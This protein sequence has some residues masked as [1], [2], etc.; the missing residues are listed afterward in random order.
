MTEIAERLQFAV[1]IA[2][3][4]GDGTLR[5]FRRSDLTIERKADHSPVT[6]A[7]RSAEELLRQRIGDRFPE[8]GII[9]EEFGE[10]A[11]RSAPSSAELHA[12]RSRIFVVADVRNGA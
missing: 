6:V 5:Y 4:A 9:G 2:R 11:G 1:E 8:D 12:R 3:E 10:Q 7:D